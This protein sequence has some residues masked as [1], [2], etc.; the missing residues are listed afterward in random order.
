MKQFSL[1]WILMGG[2][3]WGQAQSFNMPIYHIKIVTIDGKLSSG[4]L[5]DVTNS[6]LVYKEFEVKMGMSTWSYFVPLANIKKIVLRLE[7]KN[8]AIWKG[9]LL[10]GV[11][12]S[13]FAA[14][15]LEKYP[16]KSPVLAGITLTFSGLAGAGIGGVMGGL[17][18]GFRR[19]VIRVTQPIEHPE[20]LRFKL[21][22]YTYLY[23]IGTQKKLEDSILLDERK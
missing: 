17:V 9:A 6:G 20:G 22:P 7:N 4:Y 15:S 5:F 13:F 16:T 8:S 12:T 3:L 18:G 11:T 21:L 14:K 1:F 19:K 2:A 23:N 10:G